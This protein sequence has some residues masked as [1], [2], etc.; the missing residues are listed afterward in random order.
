VECAVDGDLIG[1][2]V[3]LWMKPLCPCAAVHRAERDGDA[4]KANRDGYAS[5]GRM[6]APA[7]SLLDIGLLT[8]VGNFSGGYCARVTR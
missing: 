2:G 8:I 3:R 5:H 1:K 7:I 6:V 4:E